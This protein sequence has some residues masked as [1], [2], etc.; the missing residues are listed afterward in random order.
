M[1]RLTYYKKTKNQKKQD[2]M[3]STARQL[4]KCSV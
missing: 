1:Q 2:A 3:P 4:P